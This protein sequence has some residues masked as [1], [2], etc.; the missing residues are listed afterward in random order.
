VSDSVGNLLSA[1]LGAIVGG[2]LTLAGSVVMNRSVTARA[3][4]IRLYD[5]LLPQLGGAFSS[6]LEDWDVHARGDSVARDLE[7]MS[8]VSVIAGPRER[9][10]VANLRIAWGKLSPAPRA[11]PNWRTNLAPRPSTSSRS[12]RLSV[13]DI[14]S[15]RSFWSAGS[16]SYQLS[17]ELREALLGGLGRPRGSSSPSG[18]FLV[19][20]TSGAGDAPTAVLAALVRLRPMLGLQAPLNLSRL[21]GRQVGSG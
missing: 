19:R 15:Y 16:A 7:A 17:S 5:E 18:P 21:I 12:Y 6:F 3:A 8:R 11:L 13:L 14:R 1:L 9:S 20:S 10:A 2:V 4:R